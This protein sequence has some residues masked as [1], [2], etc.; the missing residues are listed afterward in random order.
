MI[1]MPFLL[2][3]VTLNPLVAQRASLG[4]AEGIVQGATISPDH[5]CKPGDICASGT[6]PN[7]NGCYANNFWNNN[8]GGTPLTIDI[9]Q[10]GSNGSKVYIYWVNA[11]NKTISIKGN[12]T[13]KYYCP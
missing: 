8:A 10:T 9:T 4:P 2:A 5:S 11:T 12:A 7:R 1:L 3:A 13:A 6:L